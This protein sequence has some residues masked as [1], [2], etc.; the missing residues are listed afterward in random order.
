MSDSFWVCVKRFRR[1]CIF[2]RS[3]ASVFEEDRLVAEITDQVERHSERDDILEEKQAQITHIPYA[4]NGNGRA[5]GRKKHRAG[6]EEHHRSNEAAENT[7]FG[8]EIARHKQY[9]GGD[10]GEPAYACRQITFFGSTTEGGRNAR[11]Y[12]RAKKNRLG[13]GLIQIDKNL[14][15]LMLHAT[16]FTSH[17]IGSDGAR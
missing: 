4:V 8:P 13:G 6:G 10:L 7:R 15:R 2:V 9:S 5:G 1:I 11:V 16:D 17:Q 12:S 3:L 14:I